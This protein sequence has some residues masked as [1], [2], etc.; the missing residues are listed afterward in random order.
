[1]QL[2]PRKPL[3][4]RIGV[5]NAGMPGSPG[6]VR[7]RRELRGRHRCGMNGSRA[8]GPDMASPHTVNQPE[9]ECALPS[10]SSGRTTPNGRA[11]GLPWSGRS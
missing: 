1:M 7:H 11:S 2:T 3:P 4:E 8:L 5:Q 6:Q 9:A 10:S